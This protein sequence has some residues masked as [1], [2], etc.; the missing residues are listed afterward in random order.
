MNSERPSLDK[1]AYGFEKA[2]VMQLSQPDSIPYQ[3]NVLGVGPTVAELGKDIAFWRRDLMWT[4]VA[5]TY[6]GTDVAVGAQDNT[7]FELYDMTDIEDIAP[8]E[9][10]DRIY[11]YAP[12][13]EQLTNKER[14]ALFKSLISLLKYDGSLLV[15]ESEQNAL[16]SETRYVKQRRLS[17]HTKSRYK[18]K[19]APENT[20]INYGSMTSHYDAE[21]MV[22]A[23]SPDSKKLFDSVLKVSGL[24]VASAIFGLIATKKFGKSN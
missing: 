22:S 1:L 10:F 20:V 11:G 21:P 24:A 14:K 15:T 8:P 2:N 23:I 13:F 19:T 3:A 5:E 4:N 12:D 17:I 7:S 16:P 18:A 6:E 9:Y